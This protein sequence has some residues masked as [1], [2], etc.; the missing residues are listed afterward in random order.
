MSWK[1][2]F[3]QQREGITALGGVGVIGLHMVSGPLVGFAI[4]YG[5]D[6]WLPIAPWGKHAFLLIGIG[7]GFLNVWYDTRNLVNKLNRESIKNPGQGGDS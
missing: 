7:A 5:L 3:E 2:L 4:G 6:L 1:D